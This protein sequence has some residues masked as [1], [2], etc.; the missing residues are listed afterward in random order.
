MKIPVVLSVVHVTVSEDGSI[1]VDIDGSPYAAE[2]TL[3]RAALRSVLD[4]ITTELG[5]AVRVEVREADGATYADIAIPPEPPAPAT[6]ESRPETATP[7]FAGAGFRPGEEVALAYVVSRQSADPDGNA[8]INLPPALLST[9]RGG[10]VLLGLT[11]QT[12]APLEASA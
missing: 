2:R 3:G 6:K 11:S 12:I 9:A 8:S 4:E 1:S 10:L 5:I 7:A